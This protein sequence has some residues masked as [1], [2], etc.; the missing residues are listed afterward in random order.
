MKYK[1]VINNGH[2]VGSKVVLLYLVD[3]SIAF[4]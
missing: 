2:M 1:S 4:E 3:K